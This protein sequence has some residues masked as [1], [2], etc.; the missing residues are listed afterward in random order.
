[1]PCC[2]SGR[3]GGPAR[4]PSARSAPTVP[5]A[6]PAPTLG[7]HLRGPTDNPCP[8]LA[9]PFPLDRPSAQHQRRFG[10]TR[11]L[12]WLEAQPGRSWQERWAAS[13]AGWTAG[14]TGRRFPF[15]WSKRTGRIHPSATTGY[16]TFGAGLALLDLRG[17]HLP[18][19]RLAAAELLRRPTH[20]PPRWPG[21][22]IR[23]FRHAA[24]AHPEEQLGQAHQQRR[25]CHDRLHPRGQRRAVR[26]VTVGD[27]LELVQIS[28]ANT[29]TTAGPAAVLLRTFAHMASS[30][31]RTL[32]GARMF[33]PTYQV[34]MYQGQ[35]IPRA[36]HR[37]LRP[38][39][40]PRP[41]P[42]RRLRA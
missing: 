16:Q 32:D 4:R 1:M 33:G 17:H 22:A 11:V 41:R 15:E 24:C 7:G 21:Y 9:P 39:L 28:A 25:Y 18:R 29:K 10:L 27:C 36:T 5:S 37:P 26:D 30:A 38:G 6:P 13:G 19:H 14:R 20:W 23:W 8:A 31:R 34:G 2:R 3:P 40:P 35:R 12:E 42:A